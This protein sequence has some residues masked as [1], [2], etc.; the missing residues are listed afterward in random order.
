RQRLHSRRSRARSKEIRR[1][2]ANIAS[3]VCLRVGVPRSLGGLTTDFPPRPLAQA[4]DGRFSWPAK[5]GTE[6][7]DEPL[8]IMLEKSGQPFS[9]LSPSAVPKIR[10]R[11]IVKGVTVHIFMVPADK[12]GTRW[13]A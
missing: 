6:P 4:L 12:L 5:S 10:D 1:C 3:A 9:P 13:K 7:T 11:Q 8:R 2:V